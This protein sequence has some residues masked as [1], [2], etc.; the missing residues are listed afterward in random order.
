MTNPLTAHAVGMTGLA[1]WSAERLQTHRYNLCET[2]VRKCNSYALHEQYRDNAFAARAGMPLPH[3]D[4]LPLVP[5]T[6]E[7][8]FYDYHLDQEV[9]VSLNPAAFAKPGLT[10]CP[11]DDCKLRRTI[12]RCG[13]CS[14]CRGDADSDPLSVGSSCRHV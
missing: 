9:R 8:F 12:C 2:E 13:P 10:R 7:K 11:C 1:Q 3:P 4:L 14:T 5:D 6:G